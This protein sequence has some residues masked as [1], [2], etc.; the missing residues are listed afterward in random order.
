MGPQP[1]GQPQSPQ[2]SDGLGCSPHVHWRKRVP[3]TKT[4]DLPATL[5]RALSLQGLCV[6]MGGCGAE[7]AA[8]VQALLLG[9]LGA[10]TI[11]DLTDHVTFTFQSHGR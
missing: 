3:G 6:T 10:L 5:E 1:P 7:R 2:V 8:H 11:C 9:T 4:H